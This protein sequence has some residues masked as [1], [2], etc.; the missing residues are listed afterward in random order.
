MAEVIQYR[1]MLNYHEV[2]VRKANGDITYKSPKGYATNK[3]ARNS[4]I[5]TAIHIIYKFSEQL[6]Q[7]Q[8]KQCGIVVLQDIE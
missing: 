2:K 5:D 6:N 8:K 1:T 7:E 4:A 3:E